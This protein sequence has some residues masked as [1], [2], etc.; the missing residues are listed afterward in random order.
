[1]TKIVWVAADTNPLAENFNAV[2]GE[3]GIVIYTA[4]AGPSFSIMMVI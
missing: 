1:M 3:V 4:G 2:F